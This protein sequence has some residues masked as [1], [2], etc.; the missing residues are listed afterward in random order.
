MAKDPL[1]L[2]D[3]EESSVTS[4][5][6]NQDEDIEGEELEEE[7]HDHNREEG[8]GDQDDHE[9][10]IANDDVAIPRAGKVWRGGPLSLKYGFGHIYVPDDF[11]KGRV[12]KSRYRTF[13]SKSDVEEFKKCGAGKATA[14]WI[15]QWHAGTKRLG[16]SL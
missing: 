1:S 3:V 12:A 2:S 10:P 7:G 8:G 16:I 6:H 5:A 14:K 11:P 15:D 9:E 13:V 4:K